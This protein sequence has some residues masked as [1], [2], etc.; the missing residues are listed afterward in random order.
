MVHIKHLQRIQK[1]ICIRAEN[2][3]IVFLTLVLLNNGADNR[4]D[5]QGYQGKDRQFQGTE[6]IPQSCQYAGLFF[7]QCFGSP[8]LVR[9]L[10]PSRQLGL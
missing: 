6:K 7:T 9:A 5:R 1:F 10:P 3:E 8:S 4:S 2:P